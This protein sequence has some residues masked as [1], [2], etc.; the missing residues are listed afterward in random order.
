MKN[1][2]YK[3]TNKVYLSLINNFI[4][5]SL[6]ILLLGAFSCNSTAGSD[7]VPYTPVDYCQKA[8][9]YRAD[10]VAALLSGNSEQFQLAIIKQAAA[11]F[12]CI[13][14]QFP[15]EAHILVAKFILYGNRTSMTKASE[16][17]LSFEG[18]FKIFYDTTSSSLYIS[19]PETIITAQSCT[20]TW[21]GEE[22]FTQIL[23]TEGDFSFSNTNWTITG[24]LSLGKIIA[25]WSFGHESS[26]HNCIGQWNGELTAI[27]ASGSIFYEDTNI[28]YG[29]VEVDNVIYQVEMSRTV[30]ELGLSK[31]TLNG[32]TVVP[33]L[34]AAEASER[35]MTIGS[36]NDETGEAVFERITYTDIINAIGPETYRIVLQLEDSSSAL[37]FSLKSVTVVD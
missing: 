31:L 37:S 27:E 20:Y 13:P 32:L 17:T 7:P 11:L 35:G 21:S 4:S 24:K 6:I 36:Y 33:W 1:S 22:R 15:S 26:S 28:F 19:L 3:L 10:A 9:D 14:V 23:N 16:A 12:L 18:D 30:D 34:T 2:R 5:F 29:L 25:S 8:L